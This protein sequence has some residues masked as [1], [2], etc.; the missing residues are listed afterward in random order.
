M[1]VD[2][3]GNTILE[4]KG[5][6]THFFTDDGVV[7]AVDGVDFK[8]KRGETLGIVGESGCGKSVTCLSVLR[9]IP[10]PPGRIVG[11]EIIF[12]DE[13]LLDKSE[14]EMRRIRGNAIS[15][16]F[17]EPMTSLNPVFTVGNQLMEVI[18]L[19]QGLSRKAAQEKAVE[20]LKLVGIPLPEQRINAFPHQL[21]GGMRQRVMIA[22]AISC[23]P[24][25]LFADEPT[26][27]LDVT[28][29]AQI[30]ALMKELQQKL[31]TAIMLITHDLGVV[32]EMADNILVMYAG[33]VVEGADAKTLFKNPLHPYT[34]GLLESIPRMD[35]EQEELYVIKGMIPNP[36]E[37]PAACRFHPR[38]EEARPICR[39]H[40]PVL[41]SFSGRQIRC[42]KY[43]PQWD[44][45]MPGKEEGSCQQ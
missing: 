27:A 4:I 26:T 40:E 11:G 13:N 25:L 17:Q 42:W 43:T 33:Q 6:R 30:L 39:K 23:N 22:M 29:Q 12:R 41:V 24:E 18:R 45:C 14:E 5:L 20:M 38:C 21:S 2:V 15:M 34:V 28:I 9:L 35:V 31:G 8:I 36:A 1:R 3:M 16:I 32:A 7:P 19:H 37:M 10:Q 44:E